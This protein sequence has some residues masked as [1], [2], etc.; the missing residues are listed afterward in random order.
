MRTVYLACKEARNI[1]ECVNINLNS[2]TC[3]HAKFSIAK[4][5]AFCKMFVIDNQTFP[6]E[7]KGQVQ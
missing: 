5:P 6:E 7:N 1:S 4:Y 2:L 3:H